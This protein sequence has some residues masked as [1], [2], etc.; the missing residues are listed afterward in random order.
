V[1]ASRSYSR[2]RVPHA[3]TCGHR[4]ATCGGLHRLPQLP[5]VSRE[6]SGN[7]HRRVVFTC[8][9]A[10]TAP[11]TASVLF[12]FFSLLSLVFFWAC[13]FM[14]PLCAPSNR[15]QSVWVF[16]ILYT[17]LST[18]TGGP[19]F[20]HPCQ[21]SIDPRHLFDALLSC[22]CFLRYFL[23]GCLA[24]VCCTFF[25]FFFFGLS[26]VPFQVSIK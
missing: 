25:S 1:P 8:R 19:G 11:P 7:C 9:R 2:V 5:L 13:C 17:L 12:P 6:V 3:P 26:V 18:F 21:E 22:T 24:P 4:R 23:L 14:Y 20:W 10:A 15:C 16:W